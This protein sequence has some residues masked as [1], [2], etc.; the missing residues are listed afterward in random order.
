[1]ISS[2]E[3]G[4]RAMFAGALANYLATAIAGLRQG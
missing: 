4:S 2:A 1:V 3:V